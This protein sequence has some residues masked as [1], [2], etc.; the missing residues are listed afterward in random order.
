MYSNYQFYFEIYR[1]GYNPIVTDIAYPFYEQLSRAYIDLQTMRRIQDKV[2][3]DA[4]GLFFAMVESSSYLAMIEDSEFIATISSDTNL[5]RWILE[6]VFMAS[7][8]LTEIY[9]KYGGATDNLHD[10][11]AVLLLPQGIS[12]K[13]LQGFTLQELEA[14][15]ARELSLA[16]EKYLAGSGLLYRGGTS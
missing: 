12:A 15:K 2:D 4:L 6:N 1:Q 9:Y 11:S 8:A 14:Q 10:K 7:A 3:I 5:N 16:I 13:Q